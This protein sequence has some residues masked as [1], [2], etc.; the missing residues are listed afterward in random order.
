MP[1]IKRFGVSLER[2]LLESFDSFISNKKYTN[3][4]EAIRDII[5]KS[6]IAREWKKGKIVAA[7]ITLLIEIFMFPPLFL[8]SPVRFETRD[9]SGC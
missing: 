7:V 2:S 5:R 8:I 3:R 9:S 4:S 6:L 1:N